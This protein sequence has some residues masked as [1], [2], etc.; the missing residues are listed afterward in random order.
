MSAFG[1]KR[2]S[3]MTLKCPLSGVKRTSL[4]R[5]LMSAN[6]PKRTYRDCAD[7]SKADVGWAVYGWS[8]MEL[9]SARADFAMLVDPAGASR[10]NSRRDGFLTCPGPRLCLGASHLYAVAAVMFACGGIWGI[11]LA[12][13]ARR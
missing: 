8:R 2:T 4:V 10:E 12:V 11:V 6:D 3:I 1:T 5:S 7:C 13:A 9:S